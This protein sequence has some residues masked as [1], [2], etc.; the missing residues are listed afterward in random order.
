MNQKLRILSPD[1]QLAFPKA[2]LCL[3]SQVVSVLPG[4]DV[5]PK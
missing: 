2:V 3:Q 5:D 1:D 4:Q